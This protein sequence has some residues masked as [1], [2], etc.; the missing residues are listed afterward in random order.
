MNFPSG[1][2]SA[3]GFYEIAIYICPMQ[4]CVNRLKSAKKWIILYLHWFAW[5]TD[6]RFLKWDSY[7]YSLVPFYIVIVIDSTSLI[8]CIERLWKSSHTHFCPG[9]Q[10]QMCPFQNDYWDKG[11]PNSTRLISSRLLK[12]NILPIIKLRKLV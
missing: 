7:V 5:I 3:G 10:W 4:R 6:F 11:D 12:T 1:W 2:I 9:S 8:V